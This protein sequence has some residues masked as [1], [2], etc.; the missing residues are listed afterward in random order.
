MGDI[1]IFFWYY[2][3]MQVNQLLYWFQMME[4]LEDFISMMLMS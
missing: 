2:G 3:N 1:A 4:L